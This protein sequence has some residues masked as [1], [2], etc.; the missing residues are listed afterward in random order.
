MAS[1]L[2]I[3]V[4]ILLIDVLNPVLLGA[5]V[6]TLGRRRPYTNAFSLL[7]GHTV[8]Y[9]LA[10]IVLAVGLDAIIDRLHDPHRVDY[11][12]QIVIGV[13]LLWIAWRAT[14]RGARKKE[15]ERDFGDLR[16]FGAFWLGGIVNVIGIPFALPYFAALDQIMKA[17]LGWPR[18]LI[19]LAI[20]NV[21]YAVPFAALIGLRW[22]YRAS[23]DR[24]LERVNQWMERASAVVIP[25]LLAGLG[26]FLAADAV[27]YFTTGKPIWK[28]PA[29]SEAGL[30]ADRPPSPS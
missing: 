12:I 28:P 11:A 19:A 1:L 7:L 20:Y 21:L 9:M 17:D 26:L 25:V 18:S 14:R 10:G 4:P 29:W 16:P 2:L 27:L 13:L 3:F 22:R 23:A 15:R 24:L 6:Y 5:I 30:D 8:A